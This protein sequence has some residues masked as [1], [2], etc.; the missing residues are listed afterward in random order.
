MIEDPVSPSLARRVLERLALIGIEVRPT[1]RRARDAILRSVREELAAQRIAWKN[2]LGGEVDAWRLILAECQAEITGCKAALSDMNERFDARTAEMTTRLEEESRKLRLRLAILENLIPEPCGV[3]LSSFAQHINDIP[4]LIVSVILPTRDRAHCVSDAIAS[5][6][7]QHFKNWELIIV[8][9]GS[10]DDTVAIVTPLL[11]DARIRYVKQAASGVS[12]ARNQGLKLARGSLIAYLDSDNLWYPDFLAAAA[13]AFDVNPT[14]SLVYGVLVTDVHQLDGTRLLWIPFDRDRLLVSNFIDLNVVVHR[15]SLIERYG[16]FDERL[17]RLNDWD[18]ILRFTEHVPALALPVLAAR[19]R[20]CD[21]IRITDSVPS[22][23]NYVAIQR[24]WY[25]IASTKR[26]PRVLYALWQYPQLSETHIETEIRCMLRWGVHVDVWRET[27]P[28]SPY[29]VSVPV[30][31]GSLADTVRRAKPDVIHVH[32]LRFAANQQ[33]T[34]AELGLPV[35]VRQH[36]FDVTPE[37][38]CALLD[39]QWVRAIYAFPHHLQAIDRS[40]TRLR[41]LPAVFDTTS[42]RPHAQKNR[43]LVISTCSALP[44]NDIPFFFELAKRLPEYRFV[45][46]A[47]TCPQFENY[48]EEL[49]DIHREMNSPAELIF[50]V[51]HEDMIPLVAEAG[52][53]VHTAKPPG[54]VNTTSIEVP[55]SIAEAMATGAHA[56]VRNL[57]EMQA[58]IG[59]AGT[60]YSDVEQAAETITAMAAWPEK[61]W[62]RAWMASVERAFHGHAD[63]LTLRAIFENWCCTVAEQPPA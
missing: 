36:G 13:N 12:A 30:H 38:I 3:K 27:T 4:S 31:D 55:I 44:S 2:E 23:P 29:P 45:L 19:Y 5:V 28:A 35:T 8:D 41:V 60:T 17:E 56:L 47:I 7:A 42:F 11:A 40:D 20:V 51:Q 21:D 16:G 32:W 58:Y 46:A 39:Q 48:V 43:R 33:R 37:S 10:R 26:R 52:I 24:K 57:P 59:N 18:L 9:D 61:A 22:G 62:K 6:K 34:L 25:P 54:T 53:Y 14:V 1:L 15:K 63:E 50:D 49:K